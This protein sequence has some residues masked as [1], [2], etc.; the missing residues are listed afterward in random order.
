[1]KGSRTKA[2]ANAAQGI[3]EMVVKETEDSMRQTF[4]EGSVPVS[5]RAEVHLDSKNPAFLEVL[6]RLKKEGMIVPLTNKVLNLRGESRVF[7][8]FDF[9][10]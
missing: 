2:K 3:R 7:Q 4:G 9:K 6:E 8:R 10:V 1:M 5:Q